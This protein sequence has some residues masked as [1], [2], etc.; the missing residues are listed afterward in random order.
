MS[1]R[2]PSTS[3]EHSF[4]EKH[5]GWESALQ[6]RPSVQAFVFRLWHQ[7]DTAIKQYSARLL[8]RLSGPV[9]DVLHVCVLSLFPHFQ[10]VYGGLTCTS[11]VLRL[12]RACFKRSPT[13]LLGPLALPHASPSSYRP[14][15]SLSRPPQPHSPSSLSVP[16]P[17]HT[18]EYFQTFKR[19]P[20]LPSRRIQVD[21]ILPRSWTSLSLPNFRISI[22]P[23]LV[24]T[25][26]TPCRCRLH[27]RLCPPGP[28]PPRSK[29]P[30]RQ[31]IP[32]K[33]FL[34]PPPP[35]HP[36]QPSPPSL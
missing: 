23:N 35:P 6:E 20:R 5:A 12:P 22:F 21:R 3:E 1:A 14:Q 18:F 36:P 24:S 8:V 33:P 27:L 11:V 4:K 29:S 31:R 19:T 9:A 26:H 16:S 10:C 25:S 30:A 13:T 28:R 34:P 17:Q 7:P 2:G 32:P 15:R